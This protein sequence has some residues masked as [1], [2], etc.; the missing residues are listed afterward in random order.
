MTALQGRSRGSRKPKTYQQQTYS[1]A[2]EAIGKMLVERK[3][4]T[5]INYDVLRDIEFDSENPAGS[6]NADSTAVVAEVTTTTSSGTSEVMQ[7]P[8][9]RSLAITRTLVGNRL[10]SLS[11][12]KRNFSSLH[13]Y[14]YS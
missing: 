1:N 13:Q 14:H 12:R 9:S 11:T 4:S 2:G 6:S 10:P 7:P 5:K 8:Q 3:I